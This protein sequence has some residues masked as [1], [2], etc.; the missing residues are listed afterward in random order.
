MS[1]PEPCCVHGAVS[2]AHRHA[3]RKNV[4]AHKAGTSQREAR[5]AGGSSVTDRVITANK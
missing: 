1:G 5:M 3:P 4:S 2:C